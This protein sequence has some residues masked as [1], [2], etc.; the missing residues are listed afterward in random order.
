MKHLHLFTLSLCLLA[1]QVHAAVSADQ[2]AHLG[3]DLTPVGAQK[4][5]NADGSIPAFTG[6]LPT[7][8]G[9]IDAD[10]FLADPFA[11]EKPLFVITQAN[12]T[13][14]KDKLTPGQLALFARYPDTYRI[15]VYPSHRSVGLPDKSL[16]A[17]RQ[18]ATDTQLVA[19]GNGLEHYHPGAV[20]FPNPQGR[21]GG[22]LEPDRPLPRGHPQ[23]HRDAGLAPG[24]R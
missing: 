23:A 4:A 11:N 7:N 15:P 6:G 12:A 2:A 10:G 14:Y 5:G 16:A 13:Q 24:Q 21:P 17:T 1:T 19:G 8:A 20:P 18:N 22:D 3:A 9:T